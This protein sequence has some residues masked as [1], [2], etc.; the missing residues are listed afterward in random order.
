MGSAMISPTRIRGLSELYGSWKTTCTLRRWPRSAVPVS[1]ARLRPSNS[2]APAV[3]AHVVPPRILDPA[4]IHRLTAA[5]MEATPGRQIGEI[6]RL[7]GDA[8]ER[9]LDAELWNRVEQ[10]ARVRMPGAVEQTPH[11]LHLHDLAG[12]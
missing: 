1:S 4:A 3:G 10:G 7:A 8:V 2:M 6:R 5:R 11:R 9:L 12:V